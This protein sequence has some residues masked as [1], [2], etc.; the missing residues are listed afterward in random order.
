MDTAIAALQCLKLGLGKDTDLLDVSFSTHDKL[1]HG[2]G[3]NSG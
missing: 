2:F 1:S 3:P